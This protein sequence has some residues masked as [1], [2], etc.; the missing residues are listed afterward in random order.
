MKNWIVLL[1]M[2]CLGTS[3][4]TLSV[5]IVDDEIC[6]NK[7]ALGARC[8]MFKDPKPAWNRTPENY[9]YWAKGKATVPMSFIINLR[10]TVKKLCSDNTTACYFVQKEVEA[11]DKALGDVIKAGE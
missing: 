2:L 9:A 8:K 7:G 6:V 3:C 11:T 4:K 1:T 10:A 5:N